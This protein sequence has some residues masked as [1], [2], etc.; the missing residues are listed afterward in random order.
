VNRLNTLTRSASVALMCFGWLG[1]CEVRQGTPTEGCDSIKDCLLDW[2]CDPIERVC[3]RE[4]DEKGDDAFPNTILGR[5]SCEIT[6]PGEDPAGAGES[7]VIAIL[8]VPVKETGGTADTRWTFPTIDSCRVGE[9]GLLTIMMRVWGDTKGVALNVDTDAAAKDRAYLV[10]PMWAITEPNSL[11]LWDFE[12]QLVL[13][14]SSS[15]EV[16]L[17][18]SPK[19]GQ[20]VEVYL[21][22]SLIP[23][24]DLPNNIAFGIPCTHGVADCGASLD[25]ACFASIASVPLCTSACRG[26]VEC[27]LGGAACYTLDNGVG[28]CLRSCGTNKDKPCE[29]PLTCRDMGG[30]RVCL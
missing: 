15:G 18:G 13:A 26:D 19:V 2:V 28:R 21:K 20:T 16:L 4:W 27:V 7:D 9:D 30:G 14:Y 25:A 29:E 24:P 22:A 3:V 5:F 6:E 17:S 11:T 10:S 1:G 8:T 23:V 12:S